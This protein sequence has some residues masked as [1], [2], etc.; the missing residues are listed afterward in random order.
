MFWA[1]GAALIALGVWRHRDGVA[2]GGVEFLAEA[3]VLS[4]AAW[5]RRALRAP[6]DEDGDGRADCQ[7][8]AAFVIGSY[9]CYRSCERIMEGWEQ[10]VQAHEHGTGHGSVATRMLLSCFRMG[11]G[12]AAMLLFPAPSAASFSDR[13]ETGSVV[14]AP[15]ERAY[16]LHGW[17][18]I[19]LALCAVLGAA[20]SAFGVP[21]H[22]QAACSSVVGG[23]VTLRRA[24]VHVMRVAL[25]L[26]RANASPMR[27]V[28]YASARR[29]SKIPGV[30]SVQ[31]VRFWT[32][33][34]GHHA[35]LVVM[36]AEQAAD[37]Q[38]IRQAARHE[39]A[40]FVPELTVMVLADDVEPVSAEPPICCH[41][42]EGDN[43]VYHS[44][45]SAPG[46]HRSS[47]ISSRRC[48]EFAPGASSNS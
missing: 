42:R 47:A 14:A 8:L 11:L 40:C 44:H 15:V 46:H 23:V 7:L 24:A 36:L 34:A 22:W 20:P 35:G 13:L 10:F 9:V 37:L 28:P 4:S 48:C 41:E 12:A 18:C 17:A 21:P 38:S 30:R 29:L 3:I 5:I 33:P 19:C 27:S 43:H 31:D 45:R 26:A 6:R 39:L 16:F 2:L 25:V 1:L 32:S